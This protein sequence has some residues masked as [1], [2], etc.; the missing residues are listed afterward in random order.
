MLCIDSSPGVAIH[1]QPLGKLSPNFRLR[2]QDPSIPG[3]G[4][5]CTSPASSATARRRRRADEQA[6]GV[7]DPTAVPCPPAQRDRAARER[8]ARAP[9]GEDASPGGGEPALERARRSACSVGSSVGRRAARASPRGGAQLG[10]EV[11]GCHGDVEAD[12][13][14][15]PALLRAGPRRGCPR[16]CGRR[17]S[18]SLGHLIAR[19]VAR[20]ASATA[21]RRRAAARARA[22][23][24]AARATSAARG[25]AAP[26]MRGP[27]ARGRRSARRR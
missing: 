12:A 16:P 14:H 2:S 22:Q 6:P 13:E 1:A 3:G 27:G 9:G 15:R 24:R 4:R 26:S 25:P 18:T 8:V 7:V 5:R 21:T 10:R 19:R 20:R 11:V 23:R 17:S